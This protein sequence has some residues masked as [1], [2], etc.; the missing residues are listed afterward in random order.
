MRPGWFHPASLATGASG[1]A[2]LGHVKRWV[3]RRL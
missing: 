3:V 1:G 2:V